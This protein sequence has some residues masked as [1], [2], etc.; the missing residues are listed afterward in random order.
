M[1]KEPF[2]TRCGVFDVSGGGGGTLALPLLGNDAGAGRALGG[3][4]AAAMLLCGKDVADGG[5]RTFERM[6]F[7]LT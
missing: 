3:A 2:G 4:G 7:W 1:D 5:I 6:A